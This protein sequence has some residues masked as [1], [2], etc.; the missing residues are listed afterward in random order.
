ME[1]ITTNQL[2]QPLKKHFVDHFLNIKGSNSVNTRKSYER[3]ITKFFNCCTKDITIDMINSVNVGMAEAW[4]LELQS[5]GKSKA[6]IRLHI[7]ALSSLY[8]WLY[9]YT[10]ISNP[11]MTVS[12]NLP[13][14]ES[15]SV[16]N[17]L[18]QEEV[19][20]VLSSFDESDITQLRNKTIFALAVFTSLRRSALC[21]VKL[22]DIKK[23]L[24]IAYIDYV[25]KGGG[26]LQAK[27]PDAVM[28]LI[29]KYVQ[30]CGKCYDRDKDS[31]LFI[32]HRYN[33]GEG[34]S[35]INVYKMITSV[36]KKY[37][38]D[39]KICV[40][41]LR[42]TAL[43]LAIQGNASIEKVRDMAGHS[44]IAVTNRYISSHNNLVDHASD[45][46]KVKL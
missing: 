27:V 20:L 5:K 37:I 9:V 44:S 6:T 36:T 33:V 1:I 45:Y 13:K 4:V 10:K 24:N 12:R 21:N 15:K 43:T 18:S 34:V 19:Q 40:H 32:N 14:V 46:I 23:Y 17:S 2:Q 41:S 16:T 28:Q 35:P 31:Y 42:H 29:D 8:D 22:G 3:A 11:F 38:K 26:E 7:S 39:K 30:A 25:N